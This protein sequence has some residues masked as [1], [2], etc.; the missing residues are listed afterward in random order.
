VNNDRSR[1]IR[2]LAPISR[3]LILS[4]LVGAGA[5]LLAACA[6]TLGGAIGGTTPPY[7]GSATPGPILGLIPRPAAPPPTPTPE[8]IK[9]RFAH[10]ETGAAAQTLDALAQRFSAASS[11]VIVET[12]ATTFADH[13]ARLLTGRA[14]G[15]P[16]DIFVN[17]GVFFDRLLKAQIIRDLAGNVTAD[18]FSLDAY[19]TDPLSQMVNGH[20]YALPFW[21][22]CDLLYY[23]R[24][25]FAQKKV[26]EP[27]ADWTWDQLLAAA[28]QLSEG[29]PGAMS[30]WGILVVNDLQGGWG[31]FVASNGGDWLDPSGK[32]V[33]LGAAP[34]QEAL[35]WVVDAIVVHQ[36][37]PSAIEQQQ[38]SQAGSVDPFLDGQVAMIVNGTWEMPNALTGA[39]F[40]WDVQQIPRAPRTGQSVATTSVQPISTARASVYPDQGW[41]FL[42]FALGTAAQTLLAK[43]KIK[44]PVRKDVVNT[45]G[46]GYVIVPPAHAGVAFDAM[47][48][49]HDLHFVPRWQE[50]RTAVVRALDPA[51]AGSQPLVDALKT[52]VSAG[53]AALAG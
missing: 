7:A 43:D 11:G 5:S 50:F 24:D 38:I 48:H 49:G 41:S 26:G 15:M 47:E 22:A 37:A 1:G 45:A 18:G 42:K 23:N 28:R 31:S 32:Q 17:S 29:K 12:S 34:A 20:L 9:L 33:I 35:Q 13:F 10:W 8:P 44:L 21:G 14:A 6:G 2:A 27:A 46:V 36:V 3:R 30:R 40:Q 4:G 39:H 19:W 51:F 52:A 16:P 53:N 25:W